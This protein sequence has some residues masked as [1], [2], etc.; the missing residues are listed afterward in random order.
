MLQVL[1]RPNSIN[2]RKVLW[3]CAELEL[4]H[5]HEPWGTAE[6]PLR[7]PEYLALNPN[8][9]VPVI[10]DGGLVLWESNT[11][12]RYLAAR[13][14][15]TD[16]LPNEPAP[17]AKSRNG[18]TG[19]SRAQHRVALCVHGAG[20]QGRRVHRCEEHRGQRG[21]LEPPHDAARQP[22]ATHWCVRRAAH[23][24]WPTSCSACQRIAGS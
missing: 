19:S 1:G 2:V 24:R 23:S 20:A 22:A 16:L 12:C 9:L 6:L 14:G 15:R 4:T 17:R 11:I 18:W 8:A 3:L 7:S 21:E 10:R 5:Q 13:E